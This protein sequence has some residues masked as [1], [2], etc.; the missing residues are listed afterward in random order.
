MSYNAT[1]I[2]RLLK[3]FEFWGN[4]EKKWVSEEKFSNFLNFANYSGFVGEW[5][6]NS[7]KSQNVHILIFLQ[8][9]NWFYRKETWFFQRR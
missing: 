3:T 6:G 8:R 9:E 4:F 1:E 5:D 7:K 2:V